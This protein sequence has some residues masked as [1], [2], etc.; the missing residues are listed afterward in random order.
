MIIEV[1]YVGHHKARLVAGG[2][3]IVLHDVS[4]KSMV[5]KGINVCLIDIN[6]RDNLNVICGDIGHVFA[7]DPCLKKVYFFA[8]TKFD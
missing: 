1:K 8:G 2:H 4:A 5:V 7:K 3:M 6:T